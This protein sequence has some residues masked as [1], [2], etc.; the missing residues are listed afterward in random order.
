MYD[1]VV[2]ALW[3]ALNILC[4][5]QRISLEL[6]GLQ[7]MWHHMPSVMWVVALVTL[8]LLYSIQ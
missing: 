1:A 4:V 7:G 6:P 3:F 5:Q 2:V 8:F